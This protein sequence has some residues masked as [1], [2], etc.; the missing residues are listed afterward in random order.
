M[1][2]GRASPWVAS[3]SWVH[4]LGVSLPLFLHLGVPHRIQRARPWEMGG[5]GREK[6]TFLLP[7][8]TVK[9]LDR[10]L[11]RRLSRFS[12]LMSLSC[13]LSTKSPSLHPKLF[14][15]WEVMVWS[16]WLL[17]IGGGRGWMGPRMTWLLGWSPRSPHYLELCIPA[18]LHGVTLTQNATLQQKLTLKF[19]DL[20]LVVGNYLIKGLGLLV[21]TSLA[22]WK[23]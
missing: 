14:F 12:L 8:S 3:L 4:F 17:Q 16:T 11:S 23:N 21:K 6:E 19:T 2:S 1:T 9:C 7:L 18:P 15:C 5:C 20:L 10:V 13:Y 22:H